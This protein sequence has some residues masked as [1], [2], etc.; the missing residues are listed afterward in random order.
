MD[1]ML[2]TTV[3]KTKTEVLRDS[4]ITSWPLRR[5]EWPPAVSSTNG[6]QPIHKEIH[7]EEEYYGWRYIETTT[8]E[9]QIKWDRIPLTLEDLLHPQE[10]DIIMT[11]RAHSKNITYMDNSLGKRFESDPQAFVLTEMRMDLNI[12]GVDPLLPD[13]AVVFNVVE[14]RE[15]STFYTREEGVLP[16][17]I[18]EVTSPST[19]TQDFKKKY[20]YYAQAGVPFY[21]ILDIEYEADGFQVREY[22]LHAYELMAGSYVDLY[23]N[24]QGRYW[25]P[26]LNVFVEASEDGI[27]CYDEAGDLILNY[28]QLA[29]AQE[30]AER[31]ADQ[32]SARAD[33]QEQIAQ[34]EADRAAE[35]ER[36]ARQEAARAAEQ[37]RIAQQEIARAEQEADRAAEQERI[38]RQEAARAAEQERIAQQETARAEQETAR[39]AEQERIAQQEADRAEQEAD[40][41]AEQEQIAKQ[42]SA[43]AEQAAQAQLDA[44]AEIARLRALVAELGGEL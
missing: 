22:R 12:P 17:V 13:V 3:E 43:R 30:A 5:I 6:N 1:Q 40:R 36:I 25:L 38:A 15:W 37:E 14:D 31:R 9:G 27:L 35:Q 33:A 23:P 29:E 4:V 7:A 26:P 18:F 41:A 10:E 11:K 20:Q 34:Q 28:S 19:R 8:V 42:E 39:A 24:T 16:S 2:T 32:E 21:V 44:E